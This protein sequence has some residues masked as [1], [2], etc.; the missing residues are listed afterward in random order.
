MYIVFIMC[1]YKCSYVYILFYFSSS[2]IQDK[3]K[4]NAPWFSSGDDD[5]DGD[6]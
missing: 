6:I 5:N 1:L 3:A 2:N 4:L